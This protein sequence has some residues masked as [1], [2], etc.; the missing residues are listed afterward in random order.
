MIR[1]E[2]TGSERCTAEGITAKT[3]SPVI[4]L[5]QKLLKA[6]H[7]PE[8]PMEVYRG[9]TLALQIRSIGEAARLSVGSHGVGFIPRRKVRTGLAHA[10]I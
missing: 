8:T 5:C 7:D 10:L 9:A 2:V 4:G 3:S 1:A 6:G